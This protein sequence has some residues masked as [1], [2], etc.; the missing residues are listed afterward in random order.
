MIDWIAAGGLGLKILK[1]IPGMETWLLKRRLKAIARDLSKLVF[2]EDG[3]VAP[4]RRIARAEVS[5]ESIVGE[6]ATI[7]RLLKQTEGPVREVEETLRAD[8]ARIKLI[9]QENQERY[10]GI[11]WI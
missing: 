1:S 3:I 6:L 7:R 4:I 10:R 2:W 9:S 11:H 8:S 5:S